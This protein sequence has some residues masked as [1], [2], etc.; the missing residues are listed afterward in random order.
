MIDV[1]ENFTR[2][3]DV[4]DYVANSKVTELSKLFLITPLLAMSFQ[5]HEN[6][7]DIIKKEYSRLAKSFLPLLIVSMLSCN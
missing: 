7:W 5:S 2:A 1:W 4:K 3:G 6:E